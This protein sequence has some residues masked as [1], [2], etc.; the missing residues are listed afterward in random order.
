MEPTQVLIAWQCAMAVLAAL[1]AL[2]AR[3]GLATQRERR[4][5]RG[6][7]WLLV[8][9]A[10]I[11]AVPLALSLRLLS[12]EETLLAFGT[13]VMAVALASRFLPRPVEQR[14]SETRGW[15]RRPRPLQAPFSDL[16][17]NAS[18]PEATVLPVLTYPDVGVAAE[19]LARAFGL[20]ERLRIGGHRVQME[21]GAGALVLARGEATARSGHSIM[22]RVR[23]VDAHCA[24][25]RA[26]GA[27]ILADPASYPYGERQYTAADFAGHVWTFSQTERDVPPEEWGGEARG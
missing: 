12:L 3:K 1:L 5:A 6:F 25:A 10:V 26:A 13:T 22:V 24:Q 27:Q 15:R 9:G 18:M 2:L 16:P 7:A 8:L 14:Q 20:R 19:W 23:D 4:L 11:V 21:A 17:H